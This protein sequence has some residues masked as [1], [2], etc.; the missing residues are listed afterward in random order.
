[1]FT[2]IIESKGEVLERQEAGLVIARPSIVHDLAIGSS[3]S[4]SGACLTVTRID[5]GSMSF[6][7]VPETWSKTKLGDLAAGSMVNLERAM[8]A[9]GRFEGHMVQGHVEDVG[10][11]MSR[12]SRVMSA[13]GFVLTIEL[14]EKTARYVIPKGSIAIDGVSLTVVSV[15]GNLCTIAL[16]PHTLAETTLGLLKEGDRVNVETDMIVRAIHAMLPHTI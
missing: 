15:A 16:I 12:E 13:E 1:M 6:D 2:G 3:V 14:T 7:V 10:R 11:V 5:D 4:V 8:R 9:D